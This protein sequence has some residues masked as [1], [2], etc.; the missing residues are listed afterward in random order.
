MN[1]GAREFMIELLP[2]GPAVE[3]ICLFISL[4]LTGGGRT[5]KFYVCVHHIGIILMNHVVWAHIP[6]TYLYQDCFG[7]CPC[8]TC[9]NHIGMVQS[10]VFTY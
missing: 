5:E 1:T 2:P 8:S 7:G 6:R 10:V 4:D 3:S 9:H